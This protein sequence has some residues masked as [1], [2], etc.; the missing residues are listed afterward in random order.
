MEKRGRWGARTVP[1]ERGEE[2]GGDVVVRK[3]LALP[4]DL[5]PFRVGHSCGQRDGG[6]RSRR[7]RVRA[8][9]GGRSRG[10]EGGP[11]GEEDGD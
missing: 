9:G 4:Q 5:L 6:G 8:G 1:P 10:S 2:G 11:G 3:G 7:R